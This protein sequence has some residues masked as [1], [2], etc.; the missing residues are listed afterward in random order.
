[1]SLER[2]LENAIFA[3]RWIQVP[4]YIGL[5]GALAIVSVKFV[6]AFIHLAPEIY[7]ASENDV[8]IGVLA[9]VDMVLVGNLLLM[10]LF[11]SYENFVSKLDLKGHED[12]PAWLGH[13]DVNGLKLK[14]IASIVAISSI[15]LLKGFMNV[16]T[17][18]DRE[19][20]WM[21]G[22]HVTFVVSGVLMAWMDRVSDNK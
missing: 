22:V 8:I 16:G 18:S 12:V 7:A 2:I 20:M 14:L 19:L 3:S 10:V 11:S 6:I 21:T 4:M 13:I 17:L 5:I 9:L 1:M 15:Q